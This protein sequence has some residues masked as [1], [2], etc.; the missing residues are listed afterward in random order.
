MKIIIKEK[1][2]IGN[3]FPFFNLNEKKNEKKKRSVRI[4][5]FLPD[6]PSL[7]INARFVLLT[8][9]TNF[10]E[11]KEDFIL[12]KTGE[13]QYL[14]S[15]LFTGGM[16]HLSQFEKEVRDFCFKKFPENYI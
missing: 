1:F 5:V 4:N 9:I 16:D 3:L 12:V 8:R 10:D 7:H 13:K 2:K 6:I 11:M 15:K 14:I